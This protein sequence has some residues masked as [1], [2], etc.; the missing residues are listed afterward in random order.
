MRLYLCLATT[1]KPNPMTTEIIATALAKGNLVQVD[2]YGMI[3]LFEVSAHTIKIRTAFGS[4]HRFGIAAMDY[5]M[6]HT[7]VN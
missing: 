5:F 1:L 7:T 3:T 6:K 2:G 4:F